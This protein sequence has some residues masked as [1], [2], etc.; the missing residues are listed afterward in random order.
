MKVESKLLLF[1]YCT[2]IGMIDE[3]FL[4]NVK[5]HSWKTILVFFIVSYNMISKKSKNT[6]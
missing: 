6:L 4:K 3:K 2:E 5:N 1:L